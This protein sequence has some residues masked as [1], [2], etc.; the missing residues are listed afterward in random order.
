MSFPANTPQFNNRVY[1]LVRLIPRGK[2]LTYGQIAAFLE[3]P[4]GARAVGWALAAL[5]NGTDVP[6]HRVINAQRRASPRGAGDS[7]QRQ[8]ERLAAEGVQISTD[9][10]VAADAMWNPSTWEIRDLLESLNK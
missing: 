9:G 10:Q 1:D 2:A 5:P 3:V 4:N 7:Q 8:L 6:W